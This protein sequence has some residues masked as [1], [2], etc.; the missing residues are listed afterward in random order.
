MEIY[1]KAQDE[2][3]KKHLIGM[4]SQDSNEEQTLCSD[5]RG[6]LFQN[7]NTP[8]IFMFNQP[9]YVFHVPTKSFK[10]SEYQNE[11]LDYMVKR[12]HIDRRIAIELYEIADKTPVRT[13]ALKLDVA[14]VK[15]GKLEMALELNSATHYDIPDD[16]TA[17]ADFARRVFCDMIKQKVLSAVTNFVEVDFAQRREGTAPTASNLKTAKILYDFVHNI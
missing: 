3:V 11:F 15:N 14:K 10:M 6:V 5:I 16:I 17:C 7:P 13:N 1:S 8:Y 4:P 2:E 9:L 12:C